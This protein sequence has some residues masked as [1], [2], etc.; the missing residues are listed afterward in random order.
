MKV[1]IRI[2]AP[3]SVVLVMDPS[4][5]EIPETM[6]GASIAATLS[7]IAVGTL[8]ALD[9]ETLIS[10]SD[11]LRDAPEEEPAFDGTVETPERRVSVCSVMNRS[12]LECEVTTDTTRVRI[13]TNHASEP[14]VVRI[15]VQ[16]G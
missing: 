6:G 13:W 11:E 5:G 3:N 14:D 2:A 9:G 1:Q 10:L 7:C 8:S 15:V 4:I 12:L 16:P